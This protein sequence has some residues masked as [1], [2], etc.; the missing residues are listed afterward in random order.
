MDDGTYKWSHFEMQTHQSVSLCCPPHLHTVQ[1]GL[2]N[3]IPTPFFWP[4]LCVLWKQNEA[5][6]QMLSVLIEQNALLGLVLFPSSSIQHLPITFAQTTSHYPT[7][8]IKHHLSYVV[9]GTQKHVIIFS[10]LSLR[11]KLKQQWL[12]RVRLSLKTLFSSF[13]SLTGYCIQRAKKTLQPL[14]SRQTVAGVSRVLGIP[15]L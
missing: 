15:C 10:L 12:Q 6:R 9:K 5:G 13:L 7:I 3:V 14:L 2:S 4:L 11:S 8:Q 1:W